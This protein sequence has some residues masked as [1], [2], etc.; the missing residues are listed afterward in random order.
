MVRNT[1]FVTCE[2]I[3]KYYSG[4]LDE[5]ID[6]NQLSS[7]ILIAQDVRTQSTL[8]YDLYNKYINDINNNTG[9]NGMYKVL[10]DSYIQP[11]VSLWAIY[12]MLPSLNFRMTNKALSTKDSQYGKSSTRNDVEYIRQQI[13]NQAQFY[14]QRC[15]EIITNNPQSFP[16]YYQ[17][18]GVNR[19][20]AKNN[21]YF[22]GMFLPDT[23][24]RKNNGGWQSDDRCCNGGGYYF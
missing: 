13:S 22:A 1:Y 5:N 12:E 3:K 15:R 21:S 6:D 19:I 17:V 23:V 10:M 8:G 2:Y 16:E 11:S 14:D 4:Y 24:I 9:P 7:F 20:K 18:T